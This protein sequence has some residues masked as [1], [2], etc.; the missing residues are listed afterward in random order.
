[1][2]K[3][4]ANATEYEQVL[5]KLL[6]EQQKTFP[7]QTFF[8]RHES[9]ITDFLTR[10]PEEGNTIA[11]QQFAR[12][13]YKCV[14]K[15]RLTQ[16]SR[17][18]WLVEA[19]V[20]ELVHAGQ[21]YERFFQ[22]LSELPALAKSVGPD[23]IARHKSNHLR[24]KALIAKGAS[25]ADVSIRLFRDAA[26]QLTSISH[27]TVF[28]RANAQGNL[29]R[30]ASMMGFKFLRKRPTPNLVAAYA[31]FGQAARLA[32]RGEKLLHHGG[33]KASQ[34]VW[35]LRYWQK[36]AAIGMLSLQKRYRAATRCIH[37]AAIYAEK[38]PTFPKQHWYVSP[39]DVK[40]Q[41]LIVKAYEAICERV[42]LESAQQLLSQWVAVSDAVRNMGRYFRIEVRRKAI[43]ILLASQKNAPTGELAANLERFIDTSRSLGRTEL[44]I[45][46]IVR[47]LSSGQIPYDAAVKQFVS[48]V[49]LD[50]QPP[51]SFRYIDARTD[52]E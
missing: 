51:V 14:W 22:L 29:S 7:R 18:E 28:D 43:D 49:V 23:W 33:Q 17:R 8:I 25:R 50:A 21:T 30:A 12:G 3:N 42:D 1:M 39:Q 26:D 32:K 47:G 10:F 45:R 11:Y 2:D 31:E 38:L 6:A 36:V 46:D 27:P 4:S 41:V 19:T 37:M 13:T 15:P 9:R 24:L 48:V 35:Y 16:F 52:R 20:Q 40:N 5:H 34:Y 44:Y